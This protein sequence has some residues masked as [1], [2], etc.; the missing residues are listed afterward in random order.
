MRS[1]AEEA[2][3]KDYR[4][5]LMQF[6]SDGKVTSKDI[7]ELDPNSEDE[8]IAGWGG[9]TEFSSRFGDAVRKAVNEADQ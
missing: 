9:L 1:V 5:H 6:D 4:A 7:S 2:I 3:G 8:G